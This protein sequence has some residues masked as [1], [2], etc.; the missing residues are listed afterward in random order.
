MDNDDAIVV[1]AC[2]DVDGF[3]AQNQ[4]KEDPHHER[5][6]DIDQLDIHWMSNQIAFKCCKGAI[7]VRWN[8]EQEAAEERLQAKVF[9]ENVA[10]HGTQA[11]LSVAIIESIG[12]SSFGDE[13]R[14]TVARDMY[15]AARVAGIES[16]AKTEREK[17][18]E[19]ALKDWKQD[20]RQECTVANLGM[21]AK[22]MGIVS[23]HKSVQK[24][25]SAAYLNQ[26]LEQQMASKKLQVVGNQ[27]VHGKTEELAA[28]SVSQGARNSV[29]AL[30]M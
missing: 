5:Y 21:D 20:K 11:R 28:L 8:E 6:K 2:C 10:D 15:E 24:L 26:E 23:G 7:E 13:N 25:L 18:K 4:D 3:Q 1:N 22:N 9:E 16:G 17:L 30:T 12:A 29:R 27:A 19:P 14:A